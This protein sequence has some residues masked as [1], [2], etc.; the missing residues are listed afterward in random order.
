MVVK[1]KRLK[2]IEAYEYYF[3]TGG[4]L[5]KESIKKTMKKI[6]AGR[7]SKLYKYAG[8]L[9]GRRSILQVAKRFN[10][11][12]T[13]VYNWC[14]SFNWKERVRERDKEINKRVFELEKE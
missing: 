11:S 2:H 3:I 8:G 7:G 10:V 5:S 14:R 1:R 6:G 4:F 13:A 9:S 12:R